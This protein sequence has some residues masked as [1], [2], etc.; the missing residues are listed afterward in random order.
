MKK[1][2]LTQGREALVDDNDF[3]VLNGHKWSAEKRKHTFY[4]IR[5][6]DG[7]KTVYMHRQILA[8]PKG[9]V[10]DHDDH[11]GLNNQ[12]NNLQL[13]SSGQNNMNRRGLEAKNT[14][15]VSGVHWFKRDQKWHAQVRHNGKR[16]H[17][18]YFRHLEDAAMAVINFNPEKATE[19]E[20][21]TAAPSTAVA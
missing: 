1:I 8:A 16:V 5:K 11:D 12:K 6:N 19:S 13:V 7:N 3:E 17:L 4:A 9:R 15:G 21:C 20:L 2:Q 14:S 10:V 18:G